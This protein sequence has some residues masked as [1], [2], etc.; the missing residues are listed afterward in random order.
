MIVLILV[1][2][3]MSPGKF[4]ITVRAWWVLL[5]DLKMHN[6]FIDKNHC[7]FT[8]LRNLWQLAYTMSSH[9]NKRKV[10]KIKL[11]PE[12]QLRETNN[13]KVLF[14]L[15]IMGRDTFWWYW[16][17]EKIP[18]CVSSRLIAPNGWKKKHVKKIANKWIC[19][20][21]TN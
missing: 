20:K 12:A 18:A 14:P 1:I 15:I 16:S 5:I 11:V 17:Q 9:S 8:L 3:H 7:I 13:W 19:L 2:K 10:P 6:K 4:P 21:L